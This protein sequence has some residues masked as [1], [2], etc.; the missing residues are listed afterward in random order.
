MARGWFVGR[1]SGGGLAGWALFGGLWCLPPSLRAPLG[2]L[3]SAVFLAL[4]GLCVLFCVSV[5]L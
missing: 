4:S 1:L 2:G 3:S 5:M